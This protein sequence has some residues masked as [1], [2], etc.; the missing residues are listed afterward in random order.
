MLLFIGNLNAP[1]WRHTHR[2]ASLQYHTE[3]SAGFELTK[4]GPQACCADLRLVLDTDHAGVQAWGNLL[5]LAVLLFFMAVL[6]QYG[7]TY[8]PTRLSIVWRLQYG[9]G[10]IPICYMVYHR[11]FKLQESEVWK[12]RLGWSK[13]GDGAP[14]AGLE[15]AP[16]WKQQHVTGRC[17]GR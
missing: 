4:H 13:A 3:S 2:C 9:L 8:N 5:N 10:L 12:V 17:Q 11:I 16:D 15:A 1:S 7:P 14:V 6:G